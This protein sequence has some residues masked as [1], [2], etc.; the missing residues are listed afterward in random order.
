MEEAAKNGGEA[1]SGPFSGADSRVAVVP[2]A[3]PPL[4]ARISAQS[5]AAAII[6]AAGELLR[7]AAAAEK[8]CVSLLP[9]E[10]GTGRNVT[11]SVRLKMLPDNSCLIPRLFK[12][13]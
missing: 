1:I 11:A 10:M 13:N 3:T 12:L 8:D 7:E 4:P 6:A 9:A 2:A 5:S